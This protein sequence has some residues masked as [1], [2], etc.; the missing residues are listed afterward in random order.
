MRL[1]SQKWLMYVTHAGLNS[2]VDSHVLGLM[3]GTVSVEHTIERSTDGFLLT[4]TLVRAFYLIAKGF[5]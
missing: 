2:Y 3:M 4:L 1:T 5:A